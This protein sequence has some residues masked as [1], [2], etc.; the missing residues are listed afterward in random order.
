M[1]LAEGTEKA[2]PGY[3][4]LLPQTSEIIWT[5]IFLAIFIAVFMK[6]ILPKLNAVLDERA[7]KIQGGLEKAEKMQAEA[8]RLRAD[9]ESE[10]AEARKEAAAI[11]EKARVDGAKIVEEAKLRADSEAERILATGRQQIAAE[12]QTASAQLRGEVGVLASDLAG[13]IVGESL[14]DDE[15]ASRVIDRFLAD[16]EQSSA[17]TR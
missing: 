2:V 9:Q 5:L 6:F 10:L 3:R 8:D 4:L 16:L 11:R 13:K 7:E 1:I 14:T 17:A 12:R 15:R